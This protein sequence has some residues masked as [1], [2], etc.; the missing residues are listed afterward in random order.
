MQ[1]PPAPQNPPAP[2]DL[3][4]VSNQEILF[5]LERL[6]RSERKITHLILCHINEVELRKLYSELGYDSLYKYL[7]QHL[8]YGGSAAYDRMQAARVLKISP[9][10][11]P[12]IEEGSLNLS[13]LVKVEQSLKQEQKSG[14]ALSP[15]STQ[16]LLGKL[17]NKSGSET[18]K[19]LASELNQTPKT[20]QKLKPQKDESVRLEFT[21]TQEQYQILKKAQHLISHSVPENNLAKAITYLAQ[22]YIKKV[23]GSKK[24]KA[25][26]EGSSLTPSRTE[27]PFKVYKTL[28]QKRKFISLK[29]RREVFAKAQHCCEFVNPLTG[30][31]CASQF[32]LQLDHIQ[33]LSCGGSDEITNLRALCG[34]CNWREAQRW[35]L[36]RPL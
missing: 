35:G 17:E 4:K 5:R 24:N 2:L 16:E 29:I 10:I 15:Q 27:M 11:A 25:K 32:Q 21:L 8:H 19:I 30:K 23:E 7:T 26:T 28:R 33:P 20:Q 14:K 6:S 12:K 36:E 22:A 13:Q 3:S 31:R 1:Q 9:E 18:E 34:V